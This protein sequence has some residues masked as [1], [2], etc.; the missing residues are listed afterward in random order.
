[1]E[2]GPFR[3]KKKM[4]LLQK[5]LQN[6][7]KKLPQAKVIRAKRESES[8]GEGVDIIGDVVSI[9]NVKVRYMIKDDMMYFHRM[10]IFEAIGLER[11]LILNSK[12]I[13][14]INK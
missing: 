1:M 5:E 10:T 12:G 3:N 4:K 2:S 6:G 9:G 11:A 13:P 14:A 8:K 7:M